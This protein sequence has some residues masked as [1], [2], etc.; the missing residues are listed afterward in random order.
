M[1]PSH[2]LDKA[3]ERLS[4]QG[5]RNYEYFVAKTQQQLDEFK[6]WNELVCCEHL[7]NRGASLLLQEKMLQL[8]MIWLELRKQDSI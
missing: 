1:K 3:S 6:S 8:I 7:V 4:F 5:E 2:L